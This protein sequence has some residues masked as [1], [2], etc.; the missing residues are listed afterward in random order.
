MTA[1]II[2]IQDAIDQ[3]EK[4]G[5]ISVLSRP[6]RV[7]AIKEQAGFYPQSNEEA[8]RATTLIGREGQSNPTLR[9]LDEVYAHQRRYKADAPE[10]LR[11]VVR[12]FEEYAGNAVNEL[13]YTESFLESMNALA[14]HNLAS[15]ATIFPTEDWE[16][17]NTTIATFTAMTRYLETEQFAETENDDRLG[18]RELIDYTSGEQRIERIIDTLGVL[19]ATSLQRTARA[20]KTNQEHRFDFWVDKLEASRRHLFVR[21]IAGV[22]LEELYRISHE[23]H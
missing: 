16:H 12:S 11:S 2:S 7:K 15:F 3:I 4:D 14:P 22:A 9:H 20:V 10:A 6:E 21:D 18:K 5:R 19:R 1:E 17:D 8:S 13:Y 23:R